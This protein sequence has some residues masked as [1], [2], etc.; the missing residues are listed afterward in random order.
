MFVKTNTIPTTVCDE[1]WY[2]YIYIYIERKRPRQ[3]QKRED[4]DEYYERVVSSSNS[5]SSS[6]SSI[7]SIMRQYFLVTLLPSALSMISP[8][9]VMTINAL[10]TAHSLTPTRDKSSTR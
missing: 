10:M 3:R 2:I 1:E 8:R 5:S 4:F 9:W 7:F 6:S